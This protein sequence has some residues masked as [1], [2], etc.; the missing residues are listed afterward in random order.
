MSV[1]YMNPWLSIARMRRIEK[2]LQTLFVGKQYRACAKELAQYAYVHDDW[3]DN[4]VIYSSV[5]VKDIIESL[6]ISEI[7]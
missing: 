2:E 7:Q 5:G 4:F 1:F 6:E 3:Q